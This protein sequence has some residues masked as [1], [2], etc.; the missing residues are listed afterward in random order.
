MTY[1]T[2]RTAKQHYEI[3]DTQR[4]GIMLFGTEVKSVRSGKASLVGAKVLIRGGEVF[5]VGATIPPHQE[6]NAPPSYDSERPRRLLLHKKEIGRLYAQ[7]EMRGLTLVPICM[8]NC[9]R[10]LKMDIGVARKK[11]ARDKREDIRKRESERSVKRHM[12]R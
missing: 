7:T 4:A 5:L 10:V 2:N 9:N 11:N 8:Y 6:K 12:K 1:V 3:L